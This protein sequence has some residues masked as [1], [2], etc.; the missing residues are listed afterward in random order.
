MA[1]V[2][3]LMQCM[4]GYM[5]VAYPHYAAS[6]FAMNDFARS[7]LAFAAV[8]WSGPL[9]ARLGVEGGTSLIG[10]LTVPCVLGIWVLYFY[11]EK[12]RK[13]SRFAG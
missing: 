8:L 3:T 12:L 6:L 1:G 5:A 4:F 2:V 7:T 13:R 10:A 11:G 9:Y